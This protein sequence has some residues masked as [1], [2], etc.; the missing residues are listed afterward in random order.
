M[1]NNLNVTV[2]KNSRSIFSYKNLT[3]IFRSEVILISG[4]NNILHTILLVFIKFLLNK[5][6]ILMSDNI[7][8]SSKKQII[9]KFLLKNLH[10]NRVYDGVLVSGMSAFKYARTMGFKNIAIGYYGYSSDIFNQNYVKKKNINLNFIFVGSFIERKG[11]L[12]LI[13]VINEILNAGKYKVIFNFIGSGPLS[14]DLICLKARFPDNVILTGEK[15]GAPLAN[16]MRQADFLLAPS[17]LDH[18]ATVVSESIACGV[19]PLVSKTTFSYLDLI[20]YKLHSKLTFNEDS[21]YDLKRSILEAIAMSVDDR[22]SISRE[23]IKI[24]SKFNEQLFAEGVNY[25]IES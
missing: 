4:W 12:H 3:N 13:E 16:A 10:L 21:I 18:W 20:P 7:Y 2:L 22:I 15:Q 11:L 8:L 17:I 14:R 25:L 6:I 1:E 19:I 5:K 9:G 24:N 23:L